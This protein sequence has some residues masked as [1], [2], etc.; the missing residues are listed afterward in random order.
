LGEDAE[1]Y[2]PPLENARAE[3]AVYADLL[4]WN[5]AAPAGLRRL[6]ARRPNPLTQVLLENRLRSWWHFD[7]NRTLTDQ[8][9]VSLALRAYRL[10]K[11]IYPAQL[12]D[13]SRDL[14]P[15]IPVDAFGYGQSLQYRRTESG[16]LLWS[17]GPD[18]K[19]DG[20]R[21]MEDAKVAGPSRFHVTPDGKGDVVGG[22]NY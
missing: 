6:P 1:K 15:F 5:A 4:S 10:E 19:D 14:L 2:L 11:G 22:V 18:R 20:G 9:L 7:R 17:V 16:Y 12:E 3:Y 13:I 21:A 8:L